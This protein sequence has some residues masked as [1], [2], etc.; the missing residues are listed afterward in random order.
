MAGALCGALGGRE[1]VPA[2]WR[3]FV[4]GESRIDLEAPGSAMAE[5]A[6][7]IFAADDQRHRSRSDA[8]RRIREGLHAGHLG[9]A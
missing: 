3:D 7:A 2:E 9:P 6:E 4:A 5:V 8:L 1:A